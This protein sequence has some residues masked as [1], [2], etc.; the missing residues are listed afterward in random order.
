VYHE[1]VKKGGSNEMSCFL[2]LLLLVVGVLFIILGAVST[3]G[4]YSIFIGVVLIIAAV[5]VWRA[6]EEHEL[7]KERERWTTRPPGRSGYR[8]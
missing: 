7:E 6:V 5:P 3:V 2:G 4:G 1:G 8:D